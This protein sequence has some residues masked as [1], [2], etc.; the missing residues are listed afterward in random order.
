MLFNKELY[1]YRK[2][3]SEM[4]DKCFVFHSHMSPSQTQCLLRQLEKLQNTHLG[5]QPLK[6]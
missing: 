3:K 2:N 5:K 1:F 4:C 6:N